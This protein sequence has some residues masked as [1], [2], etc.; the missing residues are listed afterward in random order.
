[1]KDLTT[2][3]VGS[4]GEA[5]VLETILRGLGFFT[6]LASQTIKTFDPFITGA[7]M[8]DLAIQV[9]RDRVPAAREA[10]ERLR[11]ERPLPGSPETDEE[12]PAARFES[13]GRRLRWGSAAVCFGSILPPL[14]ITAVIL[15]AL[16]YLRYFLG[17][18]RSGVRPLNHAMTLASAILVMAYGGLL[19]MIYGAAWAEGV[20]R[21][22]LVLLH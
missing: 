6:H 3:F 18:L 8:F 13:L 10:L 11:A 1:M 17:V 4:A 7:G 2:V 22:L 21:A 20:A 16:F 15:Y 14:G 12:D 19:A 9:P 5:Q